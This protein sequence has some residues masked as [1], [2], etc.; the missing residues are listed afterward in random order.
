[1]MAVMVDVVVRISGPLFSWAQ[2]GYGSSKGAGADMV[3]E[4]S[5]LVDREARRRRLS[6]SSGGNTWA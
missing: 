2:P 6:G 4:L 5:Q 1:V 3:T